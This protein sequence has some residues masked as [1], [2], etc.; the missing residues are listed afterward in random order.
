MPKAVW[1][2]IAVLLAGLAASV[3]V[4]LGSRLYHQ[5]TFDR[6]DEPAHY[7]YVVHLAGGSIPRWGDLYSGQTVG[8]LDCLGQGRAAPEPCTH[9]TDPRAYG[10]DG[11]S[12]EAQQPPLAYL[13]YVPF[14]RPHES[15]AAALNSARRGGVVW[16]V[17]AAG[18]AILMAWLSDMT[19]S[20]LALVLGVCLL[21]PQSVKAAATVTNDSAA[22]VA[23]LACIVT[24]QL[25]RRR[26]STFV[27]PALIVGVIVGLMKALFC[28]VPFALLLG[29]LLMERPR[30][31]GLDIKGLWRRRGCELSL[32]VGAAGATVGFDAF[33]HMRATTP[34]KA[35]VHAMLW[36]SVTKGLKWSTVENSIA[37]VF[38]PLQGNPSTPL[39]QLWN[40]LLFGS[41][42][43]WVLNRSAQRSKAI[44]SLA[45]STVLC[46]LLLGVGSTMLLY[47]QGRY[48]FPTAPRF[49]LALIPLLAY[50]AAKSMRRI[51]TVLVG[52]VAPALAVVSS[53]I[54]HPY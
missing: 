15:P 42:L 19:I 16:L 50:I 5:P 35:V 46:I 3:A 53:Y 45:T 31:R 52:V 51:P 11:Y 39:Y 23:G 2:V 41:V 25:A 29:G 22:I 54:G 30:L 1:L 38:S 43:G 47:W 40:F 36:W 48:T 26:Q 24:V 27:V 21:N 18:L 37:N 28:V 20:Q 14:L 13:T 33:Q 32:L 49:V 34:S 6:I 12:Y 4:S 44:V 8:L 10:P 17:V 7:D 9:I